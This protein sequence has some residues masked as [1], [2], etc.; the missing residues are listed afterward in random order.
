MQNEYRI[1]VR[2]RMDHPDEKQAAEYLIALGR[3]RN[4]FIVDAVI[5]Q[6]GNQNHIPSL[7]LNDIRKVV[8]EEFQAVALSPTAT[9]LSEAKSSD[10]VPELDPNAVLEDLSIFD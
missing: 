6:I 3:S 1:N 7:S 8:R 9:V 2:F 5:N 10:G 4:Q